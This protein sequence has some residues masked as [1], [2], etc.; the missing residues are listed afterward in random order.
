MEKYVKIE[1]KNCNRTIEVEMGISLLELSQKLNLNNPRPYLVASVNHRVKDLNYRV[2]TP[3]VVEFFDITSSAGFRTYQRTLI[4]IMQAVVSKLYPQQ[5]F[6]VRHSIGNSLYCEV[7][8]KEEFSAEEC[9][10]LYDAASEIVRADMAITRETMP[11]EEVVAEFE[12]A[13]AFQTEEDVA[14]EISSLFKLLD[15]NASRNA[16]KITII[17]A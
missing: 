1:C 11:T 12:N 16:T 2:Y 15:T 7:E 10:A 17:E 8:G 3:A 9:K 14:G 4:F 5:R 6:Y 13:G